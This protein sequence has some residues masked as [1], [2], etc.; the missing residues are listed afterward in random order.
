MAFG[1][2]QYIRLY[3][4]IQETNTSKIHYLSNC[5]TVKYSFNMTNQIQVTVKT[6][7][8]IDLKQV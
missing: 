1:K 8:Q 5:E 4:K 3:S 6:E 2:L 7:Q